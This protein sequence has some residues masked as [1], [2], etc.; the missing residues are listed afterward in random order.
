MRRAAA[1]DTLLH[2]CRRRLRVSPPQGLGAP[3]VSSNSNM[4]FYHRKSQ[5]L[6]LTPHQLAAAARG[7]MAAAERYGYCGRGSWASVPVVI[8]RMMMPPMPCAPAASCSAVRHQAPLLRSRS[9]VRIHKEY[10]LRGTAQQDA[11]PP[12]PPALDPA[13]TTPD[14]ADDD[15]VCLPA[16]R[17]SP[18]R[19]AAWLAGWLNVSDADALVL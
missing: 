10:A 13:L 3:N 9:V 15:D 2:A 18:C 17:Q 14:G 7:G 6:H 8:H 16:T 19:G 12:L 5:S 4:Y 11:T 1:F